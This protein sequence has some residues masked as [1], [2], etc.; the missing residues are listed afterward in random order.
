MNSANQNVQDGAPNCWQCR[1]FGV[2][3]DPKL[4]YLCRLMGFKSRVTPSVEVLRADG[5]RCRGFVPKLNSE[6][7]APSN[8]S[9]TSRRSA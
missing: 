1:H 5:Q 3:W 7:S 8:Y 6:Q 4:P 9:S 2:S